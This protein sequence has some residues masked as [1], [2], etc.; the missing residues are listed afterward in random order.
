M[1][2][3]GSPRVSAHSAARPASALMFVGRAERAASALGA[4]IVPARSHGSAPKGVT[5]ADPGCK[6][7]AEVSSPASTVAES[8]RIF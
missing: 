1:Q 8:E 6:E 2:I 5:E 3:P 7:S 4:I